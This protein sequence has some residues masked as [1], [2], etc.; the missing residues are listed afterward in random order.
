M[1]FSAKVKQTPQEL[2]AELEELGGRLMLTIPFGEDI[3]KARG[4]ISINGDKSCLPVMTVCIENVSTERCT[5][6][7]VVFDSKDRY[8]NFVTKLW[9]DNSINFSE[10]SSL[11]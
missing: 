3:S 9:S 10:D 1:N 4:F 2:W 5:V 11:H 8:M 6:T 7:T